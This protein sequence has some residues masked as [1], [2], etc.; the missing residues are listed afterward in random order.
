MRRF[1]NLRIASYERFVFGGTPTPARETRALPKAASSAEGWPRLLQIADFS[2]GAHKFAEV[3]AV[4]RSV[5]KRVESGVLTGF[6]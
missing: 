5:I 4:T 2:D 3:F 6:R 1:R